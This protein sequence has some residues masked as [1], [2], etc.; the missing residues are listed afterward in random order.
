[1][2]EFEPQVFYSVYFTGAG[3]ILLS[4]YFGCFLTKVMKFTVDASHSRLS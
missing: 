2:Y 3:C 4:N 1:M